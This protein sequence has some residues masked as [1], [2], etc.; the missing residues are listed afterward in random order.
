MF[1]DV[2]RPLGS[3]RASDPSSELVASDNMQTVLCVLIASVLLFGPLIVAAVL[4]IQKDKP[5]VT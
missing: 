4:S 2:R 5:E 1:C 3:P